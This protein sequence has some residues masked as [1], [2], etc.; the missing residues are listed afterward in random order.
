MAALGKL[1]VDLSANIA[2]FTSAMDKAAYTAQNRMDRIAGMAK[3]A[4]LSLIHI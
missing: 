3:V 1:V 2:Q 4:G